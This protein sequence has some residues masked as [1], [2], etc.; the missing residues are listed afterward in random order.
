MTLTPVIAVDESRCNNCH[1]CIAVCPVKFCIDGSGETVRINADLCIGCGNCIDACRQEA[2]S[3]L[4]DSREAFGALD[5]KE[6][7]I[8]LAAPALIAS[9]PDTWRNLLG[10]LKS[11]GVQGVFDVSFGAELTVRSYLDY[12][13]EARPETVIAQP[14]PAIVTY[15]QVYHPELIPRL[16]PVDSPMLHMIR[17]IRTRYPQFRN[18]RILMLSPCAAKRREF[19]E[20]GLGDFNVTFAGLERQLNREGVNLSGFPEADF[21]N[22]PAERAALFSSPGGLMKTVLRENPALEAGIRKIEGPEEI[23]PYLE[24]LES[25]VREGIAPLLVDCLNCSRGCNGGT[26]TL[27]RGHSA[28]RLEHPVRLRAL[29]LARLY[30]GPFSRRPSVRRIR[31][32]LDRYWEKGGYARKY[33][34]LSGNLKIRHPRQEELQELYRRL[35]KHQEKDFLNCSACGYRSCEMMA[36]AI[37]NGLNKVENCHHYKTAKILEEKTRIDFLNRQLRERISGCNGLIT[38]VTE[39]LTVVNRN[40]LDQSSSLEQSSSS[41]ESMVDSF[42]N[43]SGTFS[44]QRGNLEEL[45]EMARSGEQDMRLTSRAI[46]MIIGEIGRIGGMIR[47]IDDISQRTNL[48]SM[49]AAIEAAHAGSHG[50][51]FAVVASEIKKLAAGTAEQARTASDSLGEIIREAN[52]TGTISRETAVRILGMIEQILPLTGAV[53]TLLEEVSELS[54]GSSQIMDA[55]GNLKNDNR[56]VLSSSGEISGSM[57][58]LESH[59]REL[60]ALAAET[61]AQEIGV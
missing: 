43:L 36:T 52:N 7:I 15:I 21:D 12:I 1:T 25:S 23:Y 59:M 24:G 16:A 51:G 56:R 9:Y 38:R 22:P 49:N 31:K 26:G 60:I 34:D 57:E 17:M 55:I 50:S 19:D 35:L 53:N 3:I 48:L 5:R 33:K 4:D 40:I 2:R 42:R 61:A 29:E 37:F 30:R 32:T 46:E 14:C 54:A 45:M 8:A 20:T 6:K 11:R 10:W 13:G 28:D 18:H 58:E 44:S 39:S 27:V 47:M 41:V